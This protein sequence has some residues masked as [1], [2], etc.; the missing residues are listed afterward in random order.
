[1]T[2]I[3]DKTDKLELRSQKW[4]PIFEKLFGFEKRVKILPV[5]FA[6]PWWQIIWDQKFKLVLSIFLSVLDFAFYGLVPIIAGYIITSGNYTFI[7]YFVI[8]GILVNLLGPLQFYIYCLLEIQSMYSVSVQAN[9]F[10]LTVDPLAHSTRSS[11]QIISKVGRGSDSFENILDIFNYELLWIFTGVFTTI[12]AM[13]SFDS[14]IGLIALFAI[15]LVGILSVASRFWLTPITTREYIK[16]E[17]AF[18]AVGVETLA[19]VAHIR[20]S[21]ASN[22]QK[23]VLEEKTTKLMITGMTTWF[24]GV[25]LNMVIRSIYFSTVLLIGWLLLESVRQNQIP[26]AI[27]IGLFISYVNGSSLINRLGRTVERFTDRVAKADDL[28]TFIRSFGKQ[29]YPVLEGDQKNLNNSIS[30]E[31]NLNN[32]NMSNLS[33]NTGFSDSFSIHSTNLH[34]DYNE[35]TKVFED[36]SINLEVAKNQT[37]KLYGIIGPSGTGKTTLISILGGQLNPSKGE[38]LI[39]STNI[40]SINDI[41]RRKLIAMQMQSA[42]SLR[43]KLSYNLLFGLPKV[44][45]KNGDQE[46]SSTDINLGQNGSKNGETGSPLQNGDLEQIYSD[47]YLIEVLTKVGLWNLFESKEGL[48]TLI[49]EGG[50]NLSGGQRQRLNFAG[51]YLRA[52]YFQPSLVLIDEPTSSLDELSENAI[53]QMILELSNQALTLVV[54]H[55]LKTLEQAQAILDSSLFNQNKNIQFYTRSEL[56][57]HSQYY[58]DLLEGRAVLEE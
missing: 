50:L 30:Q 31:K 42:T 7:V 39:N 43:G 34:F 51:L 2:T 56:T 17:D 36:H 22:E 10:F 3:T 14:N 45:V 57:K 48:D 27:A 49:G 26:L 18:K 11:G 47:D 15:I 21:F 35:T 20:S 52:R 28:F 13:T 5:D 33:N 58:R 37:N 32:L 6:K 44:E 53:T 46:V 38:I 9:K 16:K 55:R 25:L 4:Y 1:M 24:S 54:A 41:Q 23:D 8:A 12:I 19:Q 29:T 40:Y